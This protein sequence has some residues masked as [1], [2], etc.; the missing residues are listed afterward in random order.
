M[1]VILVGMGQWDLIQ[2]AIMKSMLVT[3]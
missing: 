3:G 1:G 2:R